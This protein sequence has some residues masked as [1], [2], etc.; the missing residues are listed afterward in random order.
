[1]D[2]VIVSVGRLSWALQHAEQH[3][4]APSPRDQEH[5]PLFLTTK[6]VFEYCEL[7]LEMESHPPVRTAAIEESAPGF[8]RV[9]L[10]VGHRCSG[11]SQLKNK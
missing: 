2:K 4:R 10:G 6:H 7:S 8:T 3:P 9:S 11:V 1:M 5:L